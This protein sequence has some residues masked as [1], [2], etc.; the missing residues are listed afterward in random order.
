MMGRRISSTIL[1]WILLFVQYSSIQ[2]YP[3][4][5]KTFRDCKSGM[6]QM[7][8]LRLITIRHFSKMAEFT[9][10]CQIVNDWT[11]FVEHKL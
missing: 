3:Y 1:L 2:G 5:K 9:A 7:T 6:H 10:H 8:T 4:T 11:C